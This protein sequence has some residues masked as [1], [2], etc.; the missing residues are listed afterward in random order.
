[1]NPLLS[2]E[3]VRAIHERVLLPD[4]VRGERDG[5]DRIEAI[6]GRMVNRL[7]YLPTQDVF[8]IAAI[9][10][11]YIAIGHGFVD[12]NKRTAFGCAALT[13]KLAEMPLTFGEPPKDDPLFDLIIACAA[14]TTDENT[15]ANHLR[16]RWLAESGIRMGGHS[17]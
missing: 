10:C 7:M 8:D 9:V 12:G 13:L 11:V 4:N 16:S 15:L 17:E 3:T 14:G 5:G 6:H 1:M 2:L